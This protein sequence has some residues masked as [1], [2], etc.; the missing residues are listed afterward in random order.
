MVFF[1]FFRNVVERDRLFFGGVIFRFSADTVATLI[2]GTVF[3]ES[4][5]VTGSN[6]VCFLCVDL[7]CKVR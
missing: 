5:G 6:M 7:F 1:N 4:A 2:H 3:C